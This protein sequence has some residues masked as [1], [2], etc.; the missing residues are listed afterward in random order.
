M[1]PADVATI[2]RVIPDE[3]W[4]YNYAAG[5]LMPHGVMYRTEDG[6]HNV[7]TAP[8]DNDTQK[9]RM[10]FIAAVC[11]DVPRLCDALEQAW[12]ERSAAQA[13]IVRL[14]AALAKARDG[15]HDECPPARCLV[16]CQG[17]QAAL[18]EEPR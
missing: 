3:E 1:T 5:C 16:A 11:A 2:R 10:L 17:A 12:R 9:A 14:W 6:W 8:Y 7:C 15:L 18:M 4:R 13:R